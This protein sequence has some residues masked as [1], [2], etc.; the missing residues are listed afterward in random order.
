MNVFYDGNDD[1]ALIVLV[2]DEMEIES[3]TNDT[4][5]IPT[6]EP[7]RDPTFVED[8]C[9]AI[10]VEVNG[11]FTISELDDPEVQNNIA[12]SM[13]MAIIEVDG[14]IDEKAFTVIFEDAESDYDE[15]LQSTVIALD[16]SMCTASSGVY[17]ALLGVFAN[18]GD[19]IESV[20]ATKWSEL[21]GVSSDDMMVSAYLP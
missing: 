14:V 1:D 19:E 17:A 6:F 20:L 5:Q 13:Q 10:I 2:Y 18:Q 8:K 11:G 3:V 21:K 4:K 7:T 9:T 12:D 15:I 16:M